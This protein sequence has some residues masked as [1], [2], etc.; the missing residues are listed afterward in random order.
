LDDFT[1][2]ISSSS[3]LSALQ[4]ASEYF[5]APMTAFGAAGGFSADATLGISQ[6]PARSEP[7]TTAATTNLIFAH[8]FMGAGYRRVASGRGTPVGHAGVV[9]GGGEVHLDRHADRHD[10][11]VGTR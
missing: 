6:N 7:T 8:R 4:S 5:F 11:G 3:S 2:G 9:G 10:V 1:S